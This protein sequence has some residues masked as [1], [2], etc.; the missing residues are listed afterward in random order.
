MLRALTVCRLIKE[1][2]PY[3]ACNLTLPLWIVGGYGGGAGVGWIGEL[4]VGA[5]DV[6]L[7]SKR[8]IFGSVPE[9]A[10]FVCPRR[11]AGHGIGVNPNNRIVVCSGVV[12]LLGDDAAVCS[13]FR[14]DLSTAVICLADEHPQNARPYLV[15]SLARLLRSVHIN[16][17]PHLMTVAVVIVSQVSRHSVI[18]I[19]TGT[20]LVLVLKRD[21]TTTGIKSTRLIRSMPRVPA[22]Q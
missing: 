14:G 21:I 1:R 6:D 7:L 11:T 2:L 3:L 17:L 4:F 20:N 9:C 12:K 5:E 19:A 15:L 8:F 18:Q 16:T 10:V 13:Y 22:L